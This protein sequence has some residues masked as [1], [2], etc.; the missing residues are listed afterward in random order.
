MN[1]GKLFLSSWNNDRVSPS[2]CVLTDIQTI[3]KQQTGELVL[4]ELS[5]L[6]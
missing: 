4:S 2:P 1:V 5:T 6:M 3:F